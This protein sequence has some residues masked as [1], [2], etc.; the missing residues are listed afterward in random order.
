VYK[1]SVGVFFPAEGPQDKNT[2]GKMIQKLAEVTFILGSA[3]RN[4]AQ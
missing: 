1:G 2:F 3:P 4:E